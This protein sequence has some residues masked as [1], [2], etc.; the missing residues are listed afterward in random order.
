MAELPPLAEFLRWLNE[1]PPVFY[2]PPEG[3]PG[4]RTPVHAVVADLCDTLFGQ[5]P[6]DDLL[7]AF[8]PANA[9]KGE[10]NRLLWVLAACHLLWHPSLRSRPL[11]PAGLGKLLVQDLAALAA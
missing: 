8:R 5:P 1:M 6:A 11:P 9:G 3:F 10:H 7:Q 4:G 2:A